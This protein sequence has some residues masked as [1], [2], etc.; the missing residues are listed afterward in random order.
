MHPCRQ[1]NKA[2]GKLF[3]N[4]PWRPGEHLRP[5]LLVSVLIIKSSP[6]NLMVAFSG[7]NSYSGSPNGEW[8]GEHWHCKLKMEN[9]GDGLWRL[10]EQRCKLK[11]VWSKIHK[12]ES[13]C[14]KKCTSR[15]S[16]RPTFF[17]LTFS[18]IGSK[19]APT[20]LLLHI[21]HQDQ[22]DRDENTSNT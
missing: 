2:A 20:Q 12:E 19:E 22:E 17:N 21:W 7:A 9:S 10:R 11:T 3:E 13:S 16:R 15:K 4:G 6:N 5:S 18:L 1:L 8:P 14:A